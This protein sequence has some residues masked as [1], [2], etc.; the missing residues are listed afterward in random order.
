MS[1]DSTHRHRR[2]VRA[3]DDADDDAEDAEVDDDDGDDENDD[4]GKRRVTRARHA[5]RDATGERWRADGVASDKDTPDADDARRTG[6]V[7][8]RISSMGRG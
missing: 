3:N 7:D 8:A 1:V 5:A 4:I 6:G 2:L